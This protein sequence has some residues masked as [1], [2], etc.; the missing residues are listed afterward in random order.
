MPTSLPSELVDIY[1]HDSPAR[2]SCG[3][4][5]HQFAMFFLRKRT[6][7]LAITLND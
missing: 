3:T 2:T 6:F 4:R 5:D 7:L 1:T